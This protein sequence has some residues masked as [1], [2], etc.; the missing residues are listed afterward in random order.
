M[1]TTYFKA[2]YFKA[3][4]F[5]VLFALPICIVLHAQAAETDTA[6][7][8]SPGVVVD[9]ARSQ[10]FYADANGRLQSLGVR[11]GAVR[12]QSEE[13]A[14]P[15]GIIDSLLLVQTQPE[16][17]GQARLA[18]VNIKTGVLAERMTVPLPEDVLA[19]VGPQANQQFEITATL[20]DK[21]LQLHWQYHYRPLR[22][23]LLEDDIN[24]AQIRSRNGVFSVSAGTATA[25]ILDARTV[26]APKRLVYALEGTDALSD[27]AGRQF[28]ST[29]ARNVLASVAI[30]DA[31]FG[32]RYRWSVLDPSGLKL[33]EINAIQSMAPFFVSN[34]VLV[35]RA[36]AVLSRRADGSYS[37]LGERLV[38]Y[39][40]ST[41]LNSGIELWSAPVLDSVYRGVLPP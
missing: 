32:S 3:R 39:E 29:D 19:G 1:K 41:A 17:T 14:L 33:G 20:D 5:K 21:R 4:Y 30:D 36:A 34:S 25:A 15:L 11:D 7:T 6:F 10:I 24:G 37:Q 18:W 13:R 40:L 8:L 31:E 28:R 2:R 9:A 12:W 22:G 16:R 38:G 27:V 35:V 26:L 23:A